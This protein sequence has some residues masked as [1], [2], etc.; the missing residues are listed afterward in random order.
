M[1]PHVRA[2]I[3][4]Q[5]K[6]APAAAPVM[7]A[8]V[9]AAITSAAQPKTATATARSA[10]AQPVMPRPA[11]GRPTGPVVQPRVG[12]EY[13]LG[14]IKTEKRVSHQPV[15]W[16]PHTRGEMIKQKGAYDITADSG[17]NNTSQLEFI[18]RD[19]DEDN[20]AA[21][22]RAVNAAREVVADLRDLLQPQNINT[23][24][25]GNTARM[26]TS[27]S[28]RFYPEQ[29]WRRTI[30]QLQATAGLSVARLPEVVS[31]RAVNDPRLDRNPVRQ[32]LGNYNSRNNQAIWHHALAEV[33]NSLPTLTAPRQEVLASAVSII[34]Q[35]PLAFHNEIPGGQGTFGAK[36]DFSKLLAEVFTHLGSTITY[37]TF[38]TIVMGTINATIRGG[39]NPNNT[40]LPT[41]DI[42]VQGFT[43]NG[44][45]MNGLTIRAW[46][47]PM[48][49]TTVGGQGTDL[50]TS[51]SF[52]GTRRQR[53]ELRGFGRLGNR[54]DNGNRPIL[55]FR[56]LSSV[57]PENLPEAVAGMLEYVRV[58]NN[59]AP[60]GWTPY[61]VAAGLA[62]TAFGI[63]YYRE[64]IR[65][66]T[67]L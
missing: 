33:R 50:F 28:H 6:P 47:R 2:A 44:V 53:Q 13:E 1:A 60:R 65:Q 49:P 41:D 27:A 20:P 59:P 11:T 21:C 51:A 56:N 18:I 9:R 38:E 23:W 25:P 5:A 4:L 57:L 29:S 19:V 10:S 26:R 7:A 64:Q 14:Y 8:H 32:F 43:A 62:A 35:V 63:Y 67:G 66:Y 40:L 16:A 22:T 54:V 3:G 52:P 55:E 36:T 61:L 30:G 34:V 12:F 15:R 24:V 45:Q 31:G 39:Q 37:N 48:L 58:A 17:P 46:L 42:F